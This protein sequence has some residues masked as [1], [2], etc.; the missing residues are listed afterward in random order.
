MVQTSDLERATVLKFRTLPVCSVCVI[1]VNIC[2]DGDTNVFWEEARATLFGVSHPTVKVHKD[3]TVRFGEFVSEDSLF[4]L[5]VDM[6]TLAS[7]VGA[8]C[9]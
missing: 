4:A 7:S 2:L 6:L 8:G 1:C 9:L 5:H 3:K